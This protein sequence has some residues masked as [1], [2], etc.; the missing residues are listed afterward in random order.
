MPDLQGGPRGW[1]AGPIPRVA[2]WPSDMS[3]A[4]HVARAAY[5]VLRHAD[6]GAGLG[7]DRARRPRSRTQLESPGRRLR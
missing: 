6:R 2:C 7:G 5:D 4:I 3:R 1:F